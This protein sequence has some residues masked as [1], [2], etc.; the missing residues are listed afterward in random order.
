[1][2]GRKEGGETGAKSPENSYDYALSP[3]ENAFYERKYWSYID[4]K[5]CK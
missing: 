4:E 5:M 3:K 1:M 2:D